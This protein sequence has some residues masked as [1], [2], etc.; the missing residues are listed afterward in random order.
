M[1]KFYVSLQASEATLSDGRILQRG[2]EIELK[3][4]E[5]EDEHNAR[6]ISEGQLTAVGKKSGGGSSSDD[7][8][9]NK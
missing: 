6:L 7:T 8:G 3:K 5:I 2:Q 1:D 4:G 9:G